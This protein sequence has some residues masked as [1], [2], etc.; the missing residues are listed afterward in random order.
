MQINGNEFLNLHAGIL[1]S[2]EKEGSSGK[3]YSMDET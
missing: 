3:S 2:W 1:V